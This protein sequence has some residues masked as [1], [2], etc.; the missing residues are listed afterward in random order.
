MA[1]DLYRVSLGFAIDE[2]DGTEAGHI[3]SGSGAPGGDG[4]EQDDAPVGSIFLRTDASSTISVVY[5]KITDT[6]ATADWVQSAS[7]DYVDNL[8]N[9][10][11]WREPVLVLDSTTYADITAAETA[12]NVGDTVDGV[13]ITVGDRL[14]FTDLTTGN[15]NVYEVSGSSGNWTFTE[16]S[17]TATDGDAV[18]VQEGTNADQQW[19]Y[20]GTDW[21]QFGGASSNAELGFIRTFIGKS[22][23]GSE[24]PTYSSTN[25]VTSGT[26]LEAA[27]GDLDAAM[28]DQ[29]YTEQ[30]YVTNGQTFTASIDALDINLQDAF[31][32][33]G[34]RTYTEQN[35]VTD[36]QTLTASI[37]AL[38]IALGDV[39]SLQTSSATGITTATTVDTVLVDDVRASKWFVYAFDEGDPTQVRAEEVY[40]VHDGTA[41]ADATEVDWNRASRLRLNGNISGFDIDVVLAGTGAAQTMG[42]QIT[43]TDTVTVYAT[44]LD[45]FSV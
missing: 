42:L 4:A 10:L 35:F 15:E 21:V 18:L 11:S 27:I 24:T 37:D 12:A 17:N 40:A 13:T 34:D 38:D 14:L 8:I 23:A 26:S 28:G 5:Q 7:K 29:T 44:R 3:L 9:G 19:V 33:I 41:S 45:V 2:D 22:A 32:A 30:N 20:D 36:G 39:T 43:S 31:D 1:L 16:D 25:I 6:N